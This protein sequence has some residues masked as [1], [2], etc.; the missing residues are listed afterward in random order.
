M[1]MLWW[2]CSGNRANSSLSRR[3]RMAR[4]FKEA[5]KYGEVLP[6][7]GERHDRVHGDR[8]WPHHVL[9]DE[10]HHRRQSADPAPDRHAW[11]GVFLATIIAA[12]SARSSW[13]C[14]PM[15]R[16]RRRPAWAQR[17]LHLHGV[18][19]SEVH[20]AGDAVHGVP[21]RPHQHHHHRHQDPQDD[22]RAI[23]PML[24]NAIGGGIGIFVA[25]VACSTSTSSPSPRRTPSRRQGPGHRRHAWSGHAE[26][27]HPVAVPDRPAV[28]PSCSPCSSSRAAC[29]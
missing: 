3:G 11:G 28:P 9:R 5:E 1:K 23:P 17:V 6:F 15:C 29:C 14:S 18:L 16:T 7:E 24:Q 13:A 20:V 19:R 26:H 12:S 27:P 8:G 25:Y 4:T 21:V 2:A 10:L 22:H